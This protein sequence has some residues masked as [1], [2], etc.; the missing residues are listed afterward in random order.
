MRVELDS[1]EARQ[2]RSLVVPENLQ[3]HRLLVLVR[4]GKSVQA[5][6]TDRGPLDEF[7][8][9]LHVGGLRNARAHAGPPS[10]DRVI[11]AE[12][13]PDEPVPSLVGGLLEGSVRADPPFV[14]A[15]DRVRRLPVRARRWAARLLPQGVYAVAFTDDGG[16]LAVRLARGRSPEVR[17]GTA[18]GL[19][20]KGLDPSTLID[21]LRVQGGRP[22]LAIVAT[23]RLARAILASRRP[24]TALD[25]AIIRNDVHVA[26]SSF[27]AR[28]AL[29]F[30]RLVGL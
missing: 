20:R 11:V 24:V 4:E 9:D 17:G 21:A 28:V 12:L 3:E 25:R 22:Q 19:K 2:F 8:S 6:R 27:R 26:A 18:L 7:P 15:F 5:I 1:Q 14:P 16:V 10:L 13:E 30:L 23:E 29:F